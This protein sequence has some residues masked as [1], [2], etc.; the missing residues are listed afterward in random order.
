MFDVDSVLCP[1]ETAFVVICGSVSSGATT[2]PSSTLTVSNLNAD[3][4]FTQAELNSCPL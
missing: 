2:V 3:F 4:V 1:E